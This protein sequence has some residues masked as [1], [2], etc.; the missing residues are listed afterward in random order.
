LEH[1]PFARFKMSQE[2]KDPAFLMKEEVEVI[3]NKEITIERIKRVRDVYI[4][5][6]ST[7]LAFA[8]VKKLN[9]SEI[10]I[11][12]DGELWIFCDHLKR[13]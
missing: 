1:D 10:S 4:F 13:M 2:D 8:D 11:G 12:V 3:A 9:R 5:C 6:C 7:G